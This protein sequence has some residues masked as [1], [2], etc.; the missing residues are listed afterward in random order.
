MSRQRM[1][2]FR[3]GEWV[4]VELPFSDP[5]WTSKE[6]ALAGAMITAAMAHGATRRAAE[7]AAEKGVY[8]SL[9]PAPSPSQAQAGSF[10]K[11]MV[12]HST[13]KKNAE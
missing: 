3:K 10:G 6:K 2:F 8:E 7:L 5:M 13:R 1:L 12:A 9:Y 11:S 4:A